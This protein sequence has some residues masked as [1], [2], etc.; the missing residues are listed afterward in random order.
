MSFI[1]P[2]LASRRRREVMVA[3][4]SAYM[5]VQLSSMPIALSLPTLADVFD[6]GI[7][8]TAWIVT[9]YLLTLGSFVLLGARMGDR[10]G[11]ERVFVLGIAASCVGSL[12]IAVSTELWQIVL[13]RGLNGFGSA[14]IMG[15]ANA[16]L[17]A[18][19]SPEERGRAFA[20]PIVGARFATLC[21]LFLFAS[22]LQFFSWRLIFL[23]FLPMGLIAIAAAIPMVRHSKAP[24]REERAA[25][26]PG[27][28]DWLGAVLLVATAAVLVLSGSHLHAGE[29]SFTSSDGLSYHLPM[30]G[31]FLV[32]LAAF[33]V[34]EWRI[35]KAPIVEL[36]HFK[37]KYFSM[38]L[39]SNTTFH[40]SMLA[41]MTLV[42]ILVEEGF[43]QE[44]WVVPFVLLPNQVI[45]IFMSM[46]AG[47]V[48]DK[49]NPKLLRPGAMLLIAAG[50][51]ALG[52][53]AGNLP[54]WWLPILM[55]PI[56]VGSSMFNPINNAI[57]MS[58]LPLQ[59]RGIASGMLET[60]REIGHALGGTVSAT[61]LAMVLPAGIAHLTDAQAS[62]Y[63]FDGFV[64][65]C[66]LVVFVLIAG[67]A[68]AYFHR[69]NPLATT[70][71]PSRPQPSYGPTRG[72]DSD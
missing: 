16:I 18:T 19:Y 9:V 53:F 59:H 30:H 4:T 26:A 37:E 58:S 12:M 17:A 13:W 25:A 49:Y 48:H 31:F 65:A 57:V 10:F 5:L 33:I 24:S 35:A 72:G 51:L 20:V 60:T 34:V 1:K 52:L 61:A 7:D 62:S 28:I 50:F 22:F 46:F 63:Y 29:E 15:N 2:L 47:W 64:F 39:V 69:A 11:H 45:G 3:V 70:P 44:P 42:P 66:L 14:M 40:F 21:G 68:L 67:G 23:T 38:S 6:T 36:R 54:L 8:D 56:S 41:T 27:G 32:L 71:P 43:N 55:M